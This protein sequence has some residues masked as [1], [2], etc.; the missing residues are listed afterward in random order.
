MARLRWQAR[1]SK[2]TSSDELALIRLE[3]AWASEWYGIC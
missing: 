2:V 3:F 1:E